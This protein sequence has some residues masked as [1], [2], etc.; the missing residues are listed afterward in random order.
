MTELSTLSI[1]SLFETTKEQRLSFVLDVMNKLEHG[2]VNPLK[3][4]LQVKA[5]EEVVKLILS[6]TNYKDIVLDEAKKYGKKFNYLN[7]EVSIKEM[8]VTYDYKN[9]GDDELNWLNRQLD[10]YSVKVKNREQFLKLIPIEGMDIVTD[11]GEVK[12]IFP[13]IKNS[14]TSISVSL[15]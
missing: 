6:N 2:E 4:H 13:P 15:K 12:K 11:Q 10:S 3:M 7:S 1:L 8:G 5:L 14:T 9:T